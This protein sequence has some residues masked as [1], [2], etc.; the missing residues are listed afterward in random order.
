MGLS[1]QHKDWLLV[2]G[3]AIRKVQ[4]RYQCNL[5]ATDRLLVTRPEI[6]EYFPG[7]DIYVWIDADAWVQC[8]DAVEAFCTG[9][10]ECGFCLAP[11]LHPSYSLTSYWGIEFTKAWYG[12]PPANIRE[13]PFNAGVFAGRADAP[14]WKAWLKRV[15]DVV[16]RPSFHPLAHFA[17]DQ[18]AL[19]AMR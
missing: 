12:P 8:W 16:E 2:Q 19:N 17:L 13:I 4:W 3:A 10:V 1:D 7:H 5:S 15:A 14:H 6:P 18:S 11:E 9:A